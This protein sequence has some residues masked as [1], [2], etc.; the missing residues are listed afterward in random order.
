[1]LN[2]VASLQELPYTTL[3]LALKAML[4]HMDCYTACLCMRLH[5]T[6]LFRLTVTETKVCMFLAFGT[7]DALYNILA[8]H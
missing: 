2:M 3:T 5:N 1:M 4:I 6:T 8:Y 7:V